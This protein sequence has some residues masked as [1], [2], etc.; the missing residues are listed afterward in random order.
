MTP[1]T[2]QFIELWNAIN[3]KSFKLLRMKDFYSPKAF[4]ILFWVPIRLQQFELYTFMFRIPENSF[5]KLQN[6]F[7]VAHPH[8]DNSYSFEMSW[9]EILLKFWQA[10]RL[11]PFK[12]YIWM[13]QLPKSQK[14]ANE[15]FRRQFLQL[16]SAIVLW[17][18]KLLRVKAF[19]R[20]NAFLSAFTQGNFHYFMNW[21]FQL[22]RSSPLS[23]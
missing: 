17:F 5:F 14:R 2:L 4:L 16:L 13:L 21:K 1:H 18:I 22:A 6:A 9:S 3:W 11:Y 8:T 15:S 10:V 12:L 19:S 23:I 7:L 20:L